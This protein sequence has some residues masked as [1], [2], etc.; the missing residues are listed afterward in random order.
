MKGFIY[1]LKSD[2][3]VYYVGST[4]DID[5]R[6]RQHK[7]GTTRTTRNKNIQNLVFLQEYNFLSQARKIEKKIKNLKRKDYI[8]RIIADGYIKVKE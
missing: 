3:G 1:I 6:L 7:S 2:L 8:E 4:S 5:R